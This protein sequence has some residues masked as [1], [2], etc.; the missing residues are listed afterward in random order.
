MEEGGNPLGWPQPARSR[1]FGACAI[2]PRHVAVPMRSELQPLPYLFSVVA[3]LRE[4]EPE[5][6]SRY[7]AEDSRR[8]RAEDV[9]LELLKSTIR[10]E[11]AGHAELYESAARVCDALGLRARVHCYQAIDASQA[12]A[13][14]VWLPED[15]VHLVFSGDLAAL[16]DEHE[17]RAV[18]AHELGHVRLWQEDGGS[19]HRAFVILTDMAA[20]PDAPPSIVRTA[21]IYRRHCELYADR[22][23][24][25]ACG[26]LEPVVACLVKTQTGVRQIDPAAYLRQADDIFSRAEPTTQG[27]SHPEAYI[28]TRALAQWVRGVESVDVEIE[29]MVLGATEVDQPDLLAQTRLEQVTR[30]VLAEVFAPSWMRTE[31]ALAHAR[32]FFSDFD[33]AHAGPALDEARRGVDLAAASTASY[34]AYLLLDFVVADP[35]IEDEAAAHAARIAGRLGIRAT[36]EDKLTKELKLSRRA[37]AALRKRADATSTPQESESA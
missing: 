17:R 1:R 28:R 14:V 24:V 5:V 35:E 31:A 22:A 6:W 13:A 29:R 36:F 37:L 26:A 25:V 4:R 18:I 10:L 32:L 9:R 30:S 23:S 11:A 15:E 34:L 20:H 3:Y 33:P 7:G 16:L 21:G 8:E 27:L 12:N 19:Y 2:M